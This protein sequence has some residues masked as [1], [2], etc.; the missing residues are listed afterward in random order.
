MS[1]SLTGLYISTWRYL[2]DAETV[3]TNQTEES[4][5][6]TTT[7]G[8]LIRRYLNIVSNLTSRYDRNTLIA[9]AKRGKFSFLDLIKQNKGESRYSTRSMV[10]IKSATVTDRIRTCAIANSDSKVQRLRPLSHRHSQQINTKQQETGYVPICTPTRSIERLVN[11]ALARFLRTIVCRWI[12][13][14]PH[15]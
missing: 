5:T 15:M 1:S 6:G 12:P 9:I 7:F 10:L 11:C 4:C 3:C 14:V 13:G 8:R 2:V